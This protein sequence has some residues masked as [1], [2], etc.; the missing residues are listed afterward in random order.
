MADDLSLC[1]HQEMDRYFKAR[2]TAGG[3]Y[4]GQEPSVGDS[5]ASSVPRENPDAR[6]NSINP[7]IERCMRVHGY[8]GTSEN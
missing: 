1:K 3:M 5:V 2:L 7:N 4:T 8:E 6:A